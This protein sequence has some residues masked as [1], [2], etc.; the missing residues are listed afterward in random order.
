VN[1]EGPK[2]TGC[3]TKPSGVHVRDRR[4]IYW[5]LGDTTLN[6]GDEGWHKLVARLA[7]TEDAEPQPGA[8]ETRWEI[9]N[10]SENMG[11][12]LGILQLGPDF[13]GKGK[14]PAEEEDDPFADSSQ[15]A[16]E[17]NGGQSAHW[18]EV[19]TSRKLINSK[20]EIK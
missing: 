13:K 2:A 16:V 15:P 12:K 7:G 14:A 5:R 17:E 20:Y 4:T 8:I 18:V 11:S 1:Y 6:P 9:T 10:S 19:E 3:Q